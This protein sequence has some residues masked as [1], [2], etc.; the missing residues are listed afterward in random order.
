MFINSHSLKFRD[1]AALQTAKAKIN[2]L[3]YYFRDKQTKTPTVRGV[4]LWN[5]FD[6]ELKI[7]RLIHIIGKNGLEINNYKSAV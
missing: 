4:N 1:L 7:C 2:L 3:I 6:M 5:G